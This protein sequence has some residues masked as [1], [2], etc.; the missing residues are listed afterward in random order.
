MHFVVQPDLPVVDSPEVGHTG[1][2]MSQS[3]RKLCANRG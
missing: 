1:G 2:L 3:D